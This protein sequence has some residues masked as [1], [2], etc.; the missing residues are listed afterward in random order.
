MGFS[1]GTGWP[2]GLLWHL[3]GIS[4]PELMPTV[5]VQ[6]NAYGGNQRGASTSEMAGRAHA[7][8]E[9]IRHTHTAWQWAHRFKTISRQP[10]LHTKAARGHGLK[11]LVLRQRK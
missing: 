10:C 8:G 6:S 3:P 11:T 9:D 7:E 4:V 5:T 2:T 1:L